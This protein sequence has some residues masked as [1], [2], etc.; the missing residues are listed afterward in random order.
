MP[1]WSNLDR[2]HLFLYIAHYK[3]SN[4]KVADLSGLI[5]A[6]QNRK[7]TANKSTKKSGSQ[8][9]LNEGVFIGTFNFNLAQ[10][11]H[12]GLTGNKP[13]NLQ[14]EKVNVLF[15]IDNNRIFTISDLARDIL[16]KSNGE[17]TISEIIDLIKQKYQIPFTEAESKCNGFLNGLIEKNIVYLK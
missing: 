4:N 8:P 6:I 17:S 3:G 5:R 16:D 10:I 15:D 2:E 9:V 12:S 11:I 14:K 1:I 13:G 7:K